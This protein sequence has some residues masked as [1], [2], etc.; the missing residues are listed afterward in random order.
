MKYLWVIFIIFC[1]GGPLS[2]QSEILP[3]G[4]QLDGQEAVMTDR[5]Q[6]FSY[7]V[8]PVASN[9][10]LAVKGVEGQ[11]IVNIFPANEKGEVKSG[12][13]PYILLFDA[14]DSKAINQNMGG[15][16]LTPGYYLTNVVGGGKTSRLL[17]QVK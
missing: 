6:T 11:I 8:N 12:V 16:K 7:I 13:Q 1:L 15:H 9:A 17:F 10:V 2:A 14:N 5:S 3:F 4:V